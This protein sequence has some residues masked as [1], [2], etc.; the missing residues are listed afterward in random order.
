MEKKKQK[1]G[2]VNVRILVGNDV[3][4][5]AAAC[6]ELLGTDQEMFLGWCRETEDIGDF[7]ACVPEREYNRILLERFPGR[8]EM[9]QYT[10]A[11]TLDVRKE[12]VLKLYPLKMLFVSEMFKAKAGECGMDVGEYIEKID[13]PEEV[14]KE[15]ERMAAKKHASEKIREHEKSLERVRE[16]VPLGK[17]GLEIRSMAFLQQEGISITSFL[18]GDGIFFEFDPELILEDAWEECEEKDGAI[19]VPSCNYGGELLVLERLVP[20]DFSKMPLHKAIEHGIRR[21]EAKC[22]FSDCLHFNKGGVD[23]ELRIEILAKLLNGSSYKD[24]FCVEL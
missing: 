7:G 23:F 4:L 16:T 13:Y 20:V 18:A 1:F 17:L 3:Y 5:Q 14:Q 6:A 24:A 9:I 8:P 10:W 12:N 22:E 15:K 11:D 19:T 2:P 21:S